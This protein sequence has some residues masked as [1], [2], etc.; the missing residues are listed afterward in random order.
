MATSGTYLTRRFDVAQILDLTIRRCGVPV[1][2]QTPETVEICRDNLQLLLYELGNRGLN[3]WC[4]EQFLVG[5]NAAVPGYTLPPE[6]IDV[7][8]ANLRTPS[9]R[10]TGLITSSTGGDASP[11]LDDN[12]STGFTQGAANGNLV[13]D[14]GEP[15]VVRHVGFLPTANGSYS[16]E[17]AT[18]TDGVSWVP[19]ERIAAGTQRASRWVW[20]DVSDPRAARYFRVREIAG[21]VIGFYELYLSETVSEIPMSP[22]NRNQYIELPNK[23][24]PG[25][26]LQYWM[27]RQISPRLVLWPVPGESERYCSAA[28]WRHRHIQDAGELTH[29]LEVPVRWYEGISW[30]LA[31]RVIFEIPKA[32]LSRVPTIDTERKK[33]TL[34]AEDEERGGGPFIVLPNIGAYTR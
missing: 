20:A 2:E 16:L 27:D 25:R 33:H 8:M 12:F 21:G 4:F 29:D 19:A 7:K 34:E 24:A 9:D 10:L 11:V 5:F 15:K 30:E 6:T 32:D 1:T 22:L 31:S 23:S 3:L 17:L 26:P 18:S 28:L 14:F 13:L